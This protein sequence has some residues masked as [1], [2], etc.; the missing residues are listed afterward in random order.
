MLKILEAK[1]VPHTAQLPYPP[2][3]VQGMIPGG[4]RAWSLCK[5]EDDRKTARNVS[6]QIQCPGSSSPLIST[7]TS[8]LALHSHPLCAHWS[9]SCK[10]LAFAWVWARTVGMQRRIFFWSCPQRSY[11][12]PG[13][14]GRNKVR[15]ASMVGKGAGFHLCATWHFLIGSKFFKRG[16]KRQGPTS[17][18]QAVY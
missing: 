6:W 11:S 3:Q 18:C 17:E 4:T 1:W 7:T 13:E 16:K 15:Q 2:K 10:G 5:L 8:F 12:P 14:E 9:S